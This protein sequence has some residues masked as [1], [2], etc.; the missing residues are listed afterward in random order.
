LRMVDDCCAMCTMTASE[1]RL[2]VPLPPPPLP[3]PSFLSRESRTA[4]QF[5]SCAVITCVPPLHAT[6]RTSHLTPHTSHLTPH[7][8]HLTPHTSHLT[9]HTSHLTPHTSYLTPHT[10]HLTPHTS[11]LTPHTSHLTPQTS[12]LTPHTSHLTPHTSHFT[13]HTSHLSPPTQ[14]HR[15]QGSI[16]PRAGSPTTPIHT[17]STPKTPNQ[18]K[19][20]ISQFL[21]NVTHYTSPAVG[22]KGCCFRGAEPDATA[23]QQ[24]CDV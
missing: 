10:S 18:R 22:H 3:H 24:A 12:H 7:T 21:P 5:D 17:I 13:P 14:L 11:H 15:R 20:F 9:P 2:N 8:S 1:L 19:N 6:P 23:T 4:I 16:L